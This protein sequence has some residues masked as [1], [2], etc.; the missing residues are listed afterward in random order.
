[1][2][3]PQRL[4]TLK[5]SSSQLPIQAIPRTTHRSVLPP[6]GQ[7][8]NCWRQNKTSPSWDRDIISN[9]WHC[10]A[11]MGTVITCTST[12]SFVLRKPLCLDEGCTQKSKYDNQQVIALIAVVR[13][14]AHAPTCMNSCA[15]RQYCSFDCIGS[16]STIDKH[17]RTVISEHDWQTQERAGLLR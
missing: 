6:V 14:A 13:R 7:N 2:F 11:W 12:I 8:N 15:A 9:I 17:A 1:M 3:R 16:K 10:R 5:S 4:C